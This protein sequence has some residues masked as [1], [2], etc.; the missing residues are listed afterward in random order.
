[1]HFI[2][3]P[4]G[5]SGFKA[6]SC[7]AAKALPSPRDESAANFQVYPR[8]LKKKKKNLFKLWG[9]CS[10][11]A[12]SNPTSDDVGVTVKTRHAVS[13]HRTCMKVHPH[14]EQRPCDGHERLA[15]VVGVKSDAADSLVDRVHQE[16]VHTCTAMTN[17]PLRLKQEKSMRDV[18]KYKFTA[19]PKW[20]KGTVG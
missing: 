20:F 8:I 11:S 7:T 2:C 10:I 17:R 19:A 13:R 1:M 3:K 12:V 14:G 18:W 15:V 16:G 4:L 6:C 9:I 5:N